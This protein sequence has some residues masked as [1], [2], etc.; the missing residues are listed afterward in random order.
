MINHASFKLP[1][2]TDWHLKGFSFPPSFRPNILQS[3]RNSI[4]QCKWPFVLVWWS[5]YKFLIS[6]YKLSFN[7]F[8]LINVFD[9]MIVEDCSMIPPPPMHTHS[10]CNL[11]KIWYCNICFSCFLVL[12]L[13]VDA[14]SRFH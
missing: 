8:F 3:S 10:A 9:K 7:H 13:N 5:Q 12:F 1:S 4:C 11:Q 2:M 14:G 6:C